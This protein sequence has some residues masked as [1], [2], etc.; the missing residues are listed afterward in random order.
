L[1]KAGCFLSLCALCTIRGFIEFL[2][3][4]IKNEPFSAKKWGFFAFSWVFENTALKVR[5]S[6]LLC[7]P[8]GVPGAV[9]DRLPRV[10]PGAIN[11]ST[12]SGLAAIS[13][14]IQ[15]FQRRKPEVR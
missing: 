11:R 2:P 6:Y 5:T 9:G 7:H 15:L 8:F 10:S 13:L 12:P 4:L 14:F 1:R 3:F